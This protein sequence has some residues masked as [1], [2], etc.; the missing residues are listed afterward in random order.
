MDRWAK[1]LA[2]SLPLPQPS[3]KP[4]DP[5]QCRHEDFDVSTL[6]VMPGYCDPVS[7]PLR[8][9]LR[10]HPGK[11]SKVLR[12]LVADREQTSALPGASTTMER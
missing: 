11:Y 9:R 5:R 10:V 1:R 6:W 12:C 3:S 7:V 2:V 8:D 4:L